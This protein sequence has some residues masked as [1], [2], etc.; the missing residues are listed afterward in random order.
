M[1]KPRESTLA[2]EKGVK[3]HTSKKDLRP[4]PL[5]AS[6]SYQEAKLDPQKTAEIETRVAIHLQPEDRE[7]LFRQEGVSRKQYTKT[8]I[9]KRVR[10]FL[11]GKK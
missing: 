11:D 8:S 10:N 1:E 2:A 4:R 7:E 9:V 6:L 5:H 3:W